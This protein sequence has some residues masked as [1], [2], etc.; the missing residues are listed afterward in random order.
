M[1]TLIL[2][3]ALLAFLP[4]AFSCDI[5]GCSIGGNYFGILPQF[6]QHFIG[7]RWSE[8]RFQSAHSKSAAKAGQYDSRELFRTTDIL[9]RFYP[10]RRVQVMVLLPYHDFSRIE[11]RERLHTQGIGDISVLGSYILFDSGDSIHRS[12]QHTLSIGAGLKCPTGSSERR[13]G[14]G[15]LIHPNMQPGTGAFDYMLTL[16]YTI[17]HG[18]WGVSFDA[19]G[20]LNGRNSALDFKM[21]N[22]LNGAAKVFY[23]TKL[24]PCTLLPNAGLFADVA[25]QNEGDFDYTFGTGGH[26][27]L[28]TLGIDVYMGH[29]STGFT[30]QQPLRQNI[31]QGKVFNQNRW[32]ATFNYIF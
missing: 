20:R 30:F 15:K 9:G 10:A 13:S 23:W 3:A 26:I 2:A 25:Q 21:G 4:A 8:Q 19:Q 24:G 17:R 5:C 18:A 7:I 6:H 27:E 22:R 29:F 1:R 31:G 11:G 16:A 12:W 28:A 14:E 32:M